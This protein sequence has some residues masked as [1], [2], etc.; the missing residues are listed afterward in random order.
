MDLCEQKK[1][2]FLGINLR[3]E[4]PVKKTCFQAPGS[5]KED[6]NKWEDIRVLS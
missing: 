1:V 4:E 5:Q 6:L 2:Q 3:S